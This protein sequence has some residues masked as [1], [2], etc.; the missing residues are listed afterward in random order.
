MMKIGKRVSDYDLTKTLIQRF[1]EHVKSLQLFYEGNIFFHYE[2]LY[3][4]KTKLVAVRS[5]TFRENTYRFA[6]L[7]Q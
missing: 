2:L 1:V 5:I 3:M 6:F 7:Y 4:L